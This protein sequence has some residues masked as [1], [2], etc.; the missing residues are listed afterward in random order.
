MHMYPDMNFKAIGQKAKSH[1]FFCVF[2]V[3]DAVATQYP[4]T[5]LS[6]EQGLMILFQNKF[7]TVM[8]TCSLPVASKK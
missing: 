7:Y 2:T 6:L 4:R 5:V 3:H 8:P 1:G